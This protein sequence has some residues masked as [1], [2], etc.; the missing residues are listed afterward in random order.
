M[1]TNL[2]ALGLILVAAL[3]RVAIVYQP[4]LFNLAPITA[5]AF[6]GAVYFRD[7]RLWLVPF[8]ALTLSDLWLN[9]YH[10]TH[11]GFTWSIAEMILRAAAI[12]AAV[13]IGWLVS[14]RR[15][16]P[17]LLAGTLASALV[18]YFATNTVAWLSD[19][20]Y[21]KTFAGWWQA[22]TVGRPEFPPTLW[23]FRNTLIGDV[24]FTGIFSGAFELARRRNTAVGCARV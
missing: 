5:L 7:K 3:W 15:N 17:T 6:C 18:F 4:A 13:G 10:A 22:M 16:F 1:K 19:V 14:R 11:F 21:L 2:L 12:S 20:Y 23:F 9:H 24:L 8:A